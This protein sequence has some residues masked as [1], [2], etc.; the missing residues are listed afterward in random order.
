[1]AVTEPLSTWFGTTGH[2]SVAQECARAG[3]IFTYGVIA[4]RL[5]GRRIFA[6]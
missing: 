6:A 5:A 4:V 2:F 1:M 3:A